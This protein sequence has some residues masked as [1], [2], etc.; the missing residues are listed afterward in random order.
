MSQ[1]IKTPII[2]NPASPSY[3]SII[4]T[5]QI[6]KSVQVTLYMTA[7]SALQLTAKETITVV[8]TI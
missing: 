6:K 1:N 5:L 7:Q 3:G 8:V 2:I 4:A